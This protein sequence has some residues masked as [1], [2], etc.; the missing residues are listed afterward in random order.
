[1]WDLPDSQLTIIPFI[2]AYA[3]D[4]RREYDCGPCKLSGKLLSRCINPLRGVSCISVILPPDFP[5]RILF[6][7][8]VSVDRNYIGQLLASRGSVRGN[9][10]GYGTREQAVAYLRFQSDRDSSWATGR[11]AR[12]G[13]PRNDSPYFANT[14]MQKV[15]TT[16]KTSFTG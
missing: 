10:N 15:R 3:T 13:Y 2:R 6:R 5:L 9:G 4:S 1:M 7:V 11:V 14:S 16:C 8:F 12:C